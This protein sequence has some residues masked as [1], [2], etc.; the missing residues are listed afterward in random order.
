M[1]YGLGST[2]YTNSS[3][4]ENFTL[5]LGNNFGTSNVY[6]MGLMFAD[7]GSRS[8]NVLFDLGKKFNDLNVNNMNKMFS[9][10][11]GK[12][13]NFYL[14]LSNFNFEK[15]IERENMFEKWKNRNRTIFVKDEKTKEYVIN[16][17]GDNAENNYVIVKEKKE[18]ENNSSNLVDF[19]II[20]YLIFLFLLS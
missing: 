11:G 20:K 3:I 13:T 7:I 18:G 16:L 8:K 14:D 19:I 5:I 4:V 15:N 10:M 1:F 12:V 17:L 2:Q 9:N 6:D